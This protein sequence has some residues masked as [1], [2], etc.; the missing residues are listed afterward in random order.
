[1]AKR[2]QSAKR[3]QLRP[4]KKSTPSRHDRRDRLRTPNLSR[5]STVQA[6]VPLTDGLSSLVVMVQSVLHSRIAFRLP[7]IMAGAI[8]AK[9]RRTASSWFRAAGVRDDWDCFYDTLISIGK[10]VALVATPLLKVIVARF[11]VGPEGC[12]T[13]AVDDSPTK[14]YGRKVEGANIHHHP[15][16]GPVDS[17]WLY[18]HNWVCIAMLMTHRF[19]GVIALPILSKLYVRQCDVAALY[20]KYGWEF[21]TKHQLALQL[22]TRVVQTLRA[23]GSK[24]KMLVVFDGAYAARPLIVPLLAMGVGVVSRLR[25]NAKLFDLPEPRK[26][27]QRGRP[28]KYGKNR[29][30]LSKRAGHRLGWQSISYVC[31]GVAVLRHYK[32]FLATTTI[33]D[34]PIRV[35]ILDF[36]NGQWAAYFSTDID[37]S[38]QQILETVAGRWA[39]EEYFHDTKEVWGAGKQQVRSVWSNIACWNINGWLFT[40]I[41]LESWE[42]DVKTLVDRSE[43]PWDNPNRR[44]SHAD[45]RRMIAQQMLEK[46]FFEALEPGHRTPKMESL[47][48]DLLSLAA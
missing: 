19:W 31:R 11:D 12:W 44:P 23:L 10:V 1:M 36:G 48:S 6:K 32:T 3:P 20:A 25:S 22:V 45:R 30:S 16:P 35:V 4:R 7:I 2:K 17:E 27:G 39:I 34:S 9:G 14:R 21:Q 26:V 47:I 38:V 18:G 28:R 43:R 15:T 40:L 24:A 13:M 33:L 37:M 46:R 29:I 41:E 42:T 8:L 5:Q